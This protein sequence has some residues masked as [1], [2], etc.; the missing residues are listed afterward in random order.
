MNPGTDQLFQSADTLHEKFIQV[1]AENRHKLDAIKQGGFRVLRLGKHA[2][3]K[4]E[5]G[6]FPVQIQVGRI[7][8]EFRCLGGT[9]R[10]ACIWIGYGLIGTNI[11][12]RDRVKILFCLADHVCCLCL[13]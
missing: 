13:Q 1:R 12:I 3:I 10:F 7:K 8:I 5:P 9:N 2:T 11:A 4:L 6:Q